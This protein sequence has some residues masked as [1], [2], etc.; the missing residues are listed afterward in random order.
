MY[1]LY[2]FRATELFYAQITNMS[3][4]TIIKE[5]SNGEID[6]TWEPNKCIHA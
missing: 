1:I 2:K 4:K 6:I 5:Y 3:D